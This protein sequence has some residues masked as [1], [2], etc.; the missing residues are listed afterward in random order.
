MVRLDCKYKSFKLKKTC[1]CGTKK[2]IYKCSLI[3]LIVTDGIC[4]NCT[5]YKGDEDE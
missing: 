3:G 5:K 1:S 4:R 2:M